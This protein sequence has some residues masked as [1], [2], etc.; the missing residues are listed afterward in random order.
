[1]SK[2]IEMARIILKDKRIILSKI[3]NIFYIISD[4]AHEEHVIEVSMNW[5]VH[6]PIIITDILSSISISELYKDLLSNELTQLS[7]A[8]IMLITCGMKYTIITPLLYIATIL[9]VGGYK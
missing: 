2:I 7:I 9:E 6:R 4:P 5:V 8:N 1:M 3:D